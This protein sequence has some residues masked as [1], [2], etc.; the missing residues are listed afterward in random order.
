MN[1]FQMILW[2]SICGRVVYEIM[3][4][5]DGKQVGENCDGLAGSLR[6]L[7]RKK[8]VC[9]HVFKTKR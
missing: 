1:V 7:F 4:I 5:N 2:I 8:Y 9:L 6:S 3:F